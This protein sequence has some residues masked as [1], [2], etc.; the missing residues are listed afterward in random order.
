LAEIKAADIGSIHKLLECSPRDPA[1]T[2]GIPEETA[3][4]LISKVNEILLLVKEL[5]LSGD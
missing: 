4:A 2:V 1:K 5:M 3:L